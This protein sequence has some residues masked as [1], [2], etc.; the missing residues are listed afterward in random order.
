[1]ENWKDSRDYIV[2]LKEFLRSGI[3]NARLKIEFSEALLSFNEG[4]ESKAF[5]KEVFSIPAR[6]IRLYIENELFKEGLSEE[7][8]GAF[9]FLINRVSTLEGIT[10]PI[11]ALQ[12]IELFI[13]KLKKDYPSQVKTAKKL[14]EAFHFKR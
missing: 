4:L 10:N 13:D 12:Q 5:L 6:D 2:V 1:V 11:R 3:L 9:Q 7:N 8:Y 14:E